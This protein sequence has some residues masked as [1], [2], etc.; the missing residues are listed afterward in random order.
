MNDVKL[1]LT[2]L[3]AKIWTTRSADSTERV[4]VV[5]EAKT[6]LQCFS[7]KEGEEGEYYLWTSRSLNVENNN[8]SETA[9]GD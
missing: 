2:N 1:D 3:G 8:Q 5:R 9:G 4:S 6:K 7:A